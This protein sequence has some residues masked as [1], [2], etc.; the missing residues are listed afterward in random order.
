[1]PL[2]LTHP[3][4][5]HFHGVNWAGGTVA[6]N[7]Q[8][9]HPAD[10]SQQSITVSHR[11]SVFP[12][13]AQDNST[14]GPSKNGPFRIMTK[15]NIENGDH[16][17]LKRNRGQRG[18]GSQGKKRKRN[19]VPGS[20]GQDHDATPAAQQ[21]S[22]NEAYRPQTLGF[23]GVNGAVLSD[24][25]LP[26]ESYPASMLNYYKYLQML[27]KSQMLRQ[28][29]SWK[30][31]WEI[32]LIGSLSFLNHQDSRRGRYNSCSAVY[33]N[34]Q[35]FSMLVHRYLHSTERYSVSTQY[36]GD[37]PVFLLPGDSQSLVRQIQHSQ[38]HLPLHVLW[39]TYF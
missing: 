18:R 13:S 28:L 26:S 8:S 16:T 25:G 1:M 37:R 23:E 20:T 17:P 22:W 27:M 4:Y 35:F 14:T 33:D 11:T 39:R 32:I 21:I 19:A 30:I 2:S 15:E 24:A 34:R 9:L 7:S 6:V 31:S 5:N 12:R 10:S 3:Q 29:G 38:N 36:D